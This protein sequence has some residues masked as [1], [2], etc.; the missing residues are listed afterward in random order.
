[1]AALWLE[2]INLFPGWVVFKMQGAGFARRCRPHS[3]NPLQFRLVRLSWPIQEYTPDMQ[4]VSTEFDGTLA[5][6]VQ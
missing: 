3:I 1:M 6:P 4:T 5:A 2:A